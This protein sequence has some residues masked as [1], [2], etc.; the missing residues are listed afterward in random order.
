MQFFYRQKYQGPGSAD[1]TKS[2]AERHR[3]L[4]ALLQSAAGRDIVM[5]L[6]AEY[7]GILS[8]KCAPAGVPVIQSIL[9]F[10]YPT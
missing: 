4:V 9:D 1:P 7:T 3:E 2:R 6:F 5:H 10:E 8:G